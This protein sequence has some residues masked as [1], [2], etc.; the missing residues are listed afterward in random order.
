MIS[1]SASCV[2]EQL[3]HLIPSMPTLPEFCE[4][5]GRGWVDL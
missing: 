2:S 1:D 4:V 3:A 5:E